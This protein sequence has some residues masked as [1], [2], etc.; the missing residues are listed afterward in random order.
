MRERTSYGE[1]Q[2]Y[3]ERISQIPSHTYAFPPIRLWADRRVKSPRVK[4]LA[5]RNNT[6]GGFRFYKE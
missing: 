2:P 6:P 4:V 5:H 1:L 3:A